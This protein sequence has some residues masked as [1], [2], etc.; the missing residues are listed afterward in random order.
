MCSLAFSSWDYSRAVILRIS[1][2]EAMSCVVEPVEWGEA[3]HSLGSDGPP[4]ALVAAVARGP[5]GSDRWADRRSGRGFARQ[6][7]PR[8]AEVCSGGVQ[9]HCAWLTRDA[10]GR[11][12]E[13]LP[14]RSQVAFRQRD[15]RQA[16][17]FG[18]RHA[19]VRLAQDLVL[20]GLFCRACAAARAPD[21]REGD[22]R[23]QEPLRCRRGLRSG[24]RLRPDGASQTAGSVPPHACA[25]HAT[26]CCRAGRSLLPC[27]AS[28]QGGSAYS[29]GS[30][31][32]LRMLIAPGIT[33]GHMPHFYITARSCPVILRA[34]S[35]AGQWGI[36]FGHGG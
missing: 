24:G 35:P 7:P 19:R 20:Q 30:S 1:T 9:G 11:R 36:S 8:A 26:R 22:T 29:S 13:H 27:G 32:N 25:Q 17:F 15:R 5:A 18:R 21:S 33:V 34:A 3:G 10:A 2:L 23:W 12:P 14:P 31:G 6:A 28:L 16:C 4:C